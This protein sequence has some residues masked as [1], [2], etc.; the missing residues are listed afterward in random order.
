MIILLNSSK[1]LDMQLPARITQHSMPKFSAECEILVKV[2]RKLSVSELAKL[3]GMSEKLAVLNAERYRNWQR[4]PGP[5]NSKQALL[6]F[7]GDVFDAMEIESYPLKAFHYAQQHLRILSGLYAILRPLDLIQPYR[8]EMA[9]KLSTP[10]GKNL[11]EFWGDK[12]HL[13]LSDLLKREKSGILVNL[14]SLEYFKAVKADRLKAT[15]ITPV[16]KEQQDSSYRVV[17]IYAKKAR[18]RMCDFMIRNRIKQPENLKS[19][20]LDGY[21]FRASLSTDTQWVFVRTSKNINR[22]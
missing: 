20:S 21:R 17:A 13:S 9:T 5:A 11:Y 1:T 18:G 22:T 2:L 10:S 16:F 7:K 12:I 3:M 14:A 4:R 8:L 15:V 6:A 19:F